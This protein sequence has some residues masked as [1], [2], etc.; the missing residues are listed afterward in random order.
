MLS[1][2][3]RNRKCSHGFKSICKQCKQAGV[4]G[5]GSQVC[6]HFVRRSYCTTCS[7]AMQRCKLHPEKT[8]ALCLMCAHLKGHGSSLC[9]CVYLRCT[10]AH[11]HSPHTY[12]VRVWR[13][14]PTYTVLM[15]QADTYVG[16][17]IVFAAGVVL[18]RAIAVYNQANRLIYLSSTLNFD[19]PP[20]LLRFTVRGSSDQGHF[21]P[22][23]TED[24]AITSQTSHG[25]CSEQSICV[26]SSQ[27]SNIAD[28]G[29]GFRNVEI[30]LNTTVSLSQ[31]EAIEQVMCLFSDMMT[32]YAYM[33]P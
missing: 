4:R 31:C 3:V 7:P 16:L 26:V 27:A 13:D 8:K 33:D 15:S 12:S 21:E 9:R 24:L 2:V 17:D 20:L 19:L 22:I 32:I 25:E 6:K 30:A 14:L 23:I 5:G 1:S 28:P 11:T 10:H 18:E 29:V